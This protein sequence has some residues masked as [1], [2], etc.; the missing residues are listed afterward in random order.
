M[1]PL[2][3]INN[4]EFLYLYEEKTRELKFLKISNTKPFVSLM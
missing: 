1:I 4:D 2:L 3:T